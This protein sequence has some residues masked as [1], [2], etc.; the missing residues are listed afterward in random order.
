MKLLHNYFV[1][2][3]QVWKP[4]EIPGHSSHDPCLFKEGILS[5]AQS[6]FV[7]AY[8]LFY[9]EIWDKML[10]ERKEIIFTKI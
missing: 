5:I 10:W 3:Q 9:S 2:S 4:G 8:F 7:Y 1:V 6:S